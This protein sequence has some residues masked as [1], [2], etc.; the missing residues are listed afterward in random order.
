MTCCQEEHGYVAIT[1]LLQ[2]Q[3]QPKNY[4]SCKLTLWKTQNYAIHH[5][6]LSH[7]VQKS[8]RTAWLNYFIP[9]QVSL[10]FNRK[11][12]GEHPELCS[13][14]HTSMNTQSALTKYADFRRS[15]ECCSKSNTL[16]CPYR[17]L[18]SWQPPRLVMRQ[19]NP[20]L[21]G[22]QK[23][24]TALHFNKYNPTIL[25]YGSAAGAVVSVAILRK[26]NPSWAPLPG[27]ASSAT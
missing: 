26:N 1:V 3:P 21:N 25:Q 27:S 2:R 4:F 6:N 5:Q 8:K 24:S 7:L 14:I 19:K 12:S 20:A 13:V 23:T 11:L 17:K 18:R 10:V 16:W 22:E 9:I 15:S